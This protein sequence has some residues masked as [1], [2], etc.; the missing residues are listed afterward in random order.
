MMNFHTSTFMLMAC[1]YTTD[2]ITI[3]L[4][5]IQCVWHVFII[6]AALL[7]N[8]GTYLSAVVHLLKAELHFSQLQLK[9]NCTLTSS[10]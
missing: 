10:N 4:K 2:V 9:Q 1:C 8:I 5:P 7:P 3:Q 6:K